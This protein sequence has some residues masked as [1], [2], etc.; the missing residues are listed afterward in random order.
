MKTVYCPVKNEEIE[1]SECIIISD[2][3]HRMLKASALSAKIEW[4][5]NQRQCCLA[6]KWNYDNYPQED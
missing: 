6:C 1:G 3:A 4:N 5:E 2:V